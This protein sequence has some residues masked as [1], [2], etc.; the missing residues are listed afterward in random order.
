MVHTV[1]SDRRVHPEVVPDALG[2][3]L[4]PWGCADSPG[5]IDTT[6]GH[7]TDSDVTRPDNGPLRALKDGSPTTGPPAKYTDTAPSQI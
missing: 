3:F 2:L 1:L 6:P 4:A 7:R 5:A